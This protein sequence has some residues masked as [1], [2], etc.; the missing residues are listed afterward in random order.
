MFDLKVLRTAGSALCVLM[1]GCA[2]VG[3]DFEKPEAEVADTWLEAHDPRVDTSSSAYK[4]WWEVFNDPVLNELIEMAYSQNLNLQVAGLRVLEARA[5]LGIATGWQYPQSQTVGASYARSRSSENAPPFSN[6]P[7]TLD[8]SNTVNVWA[9]NFNIAWEAD[10]WGRF[11]RGIE[12]ADANFA[13]N[14]LNYD[15][16]LVTLTGD[17]ALLYNSIRTLEQRIVYTRQNVQIQEQGLDLAQARFDFGATSELDVKQ[18]ES[19]L[20]GTSSVVGIAILLPWDL[21]PEKT[22]LSNG[23]L[24][25]QILERWHKINNMAIFIY[26]KN[27]FLTIILKYITEMLKCI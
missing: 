27:Y 2:T 22:D 11:R 13:A 14:M 19:L 1:A 12:A 6:L 23:L 25:S 3:P 17:V 15:A 18:T 24:A 21:D 9:L 10:I 16:V 20:Y 8:V 5:Q 4:N 7:P 26:L